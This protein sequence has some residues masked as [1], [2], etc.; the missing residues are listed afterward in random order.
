R[1][2]SSSTVSRSILATA[3]RASMS[4]STALALTATNN[5]NAISGLVIVFSVSAVAD[6]AG[7]IPPGQEPASDAMLEIGGSSE[8]EETQGGGLEIG[9]ENFE[10][11]TSVGGLEIQG[12][13]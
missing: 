8:L 7:D 1:S 4:C 9:G 3:G 11:E 2:T 10:P 13:D 6:V 12:M 5:L